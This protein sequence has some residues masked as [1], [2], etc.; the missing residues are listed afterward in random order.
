MTFNTRDSTFVSVDDLF[1][2]V[3]LRA[4]HSTAAAVSAGGRVLAFASPWNNQV[5]LD[6]RFIV[7][8]PRPRKPL[9]LARVF[10]NSSF[11]R[12]SL[13]S[14]CILLN[15]ATRFGLLRSPKLSAVS[16]PVP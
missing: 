2:H 7:R 10:F 1:G 9:V 12:G 8:S 16:D 13:P 4:L 15:D 5:V 6:V 11:W 14:S 3:V